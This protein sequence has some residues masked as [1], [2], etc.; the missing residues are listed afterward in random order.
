[1]L[2][3][4]SRNRAGVSPDL[5]RN[6]AGVSPSDIKSRSEQELLGLVAVLSRITA[7]TTDFVSDLLGATADDGDGHP[8]RKIKS[9]FEPGR[10]RVPPEKNYQSGSGMN[11]GRVVL[12]VVLIVEVELMKD[13]RRKRIRAV[14]TRIREKLKGKEAHE[15]ICRDG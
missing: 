12:F 1:M 4:L 9:F 10:A 8:S 13:C 6:R 2:P 11:V 3:K 15:G 14:A 5:N 7:F